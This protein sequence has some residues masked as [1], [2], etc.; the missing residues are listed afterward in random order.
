LSES[1]FRGKRTV[2]GQKE[3][4]R[5]GVRVEGG[6]NASREDEGVGSRNFP[7]YACVYMRVGERRGKKHRERGGRRENR[8]VTAQTR[9]DF[10]SPRFRR[11]F[12]CV[13]I[14]RWRRVQMVA[15][16]GLTP[17]T[18]GGRWSARR[19]S[20]RAWA[21]GTRRS[22]RFHTSS[23]SRCGMRE[24]RARPKGKSPPP[25]ACWC[26][27]VERSDEQILRQVSLCRGEAPLSL[28]CLAGV[29]RCLC[30]CARGPSVSGVE[31]GRKHEF[32]TKKNEEEN[33]AKRVPIPFFVLHFS[34]SA[35]R[36]RA[37]S[38][39]TARDPPSPGRVVKAP[40]RSTPDGLLRNPRNSPAAAAAVC[41]RP[42]ALWQKN[43]KKIVHVSFFCPKRSR[44]LS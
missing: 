23:T 22:R 26:S 40:A 35:H 20:C 17:S 27:T 9:A 16:L 4:W 38:L 21:E 8:N 25:R 10:L 33:G 41:E 28:A 3:V 44:L 30:D 6:C 43:R 19:G 32:D 18:P 15:E 34:F 2:P 7:I 12:L 13:C 31:M 37:L 39:P 11:F 36:L 5:R 42:L 24:A 1:V 14:S 29:R